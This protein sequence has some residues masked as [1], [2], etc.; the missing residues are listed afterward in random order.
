VAKVLRQQLA[1]AM[2]FVRAVVLPALR[3]GFEALR[4]VLDAWGQFLIVLFRRIGETIQR[5]APIWQVMAGVVQAVMP[6]IINQVQAALRIIQGII[7]VFTAVISGN[8]SGAWN[9]IKNVFGGIWDGIKGIV[10][11]GVN[12]IRSA[13]SG[14]IGWV[15]GAF[16]GIGNMILAPFR[17]AIG[18]YKSLWNSTIGGRGFTIPDIP[19]LPGRGTRVQIPTL[20]TGG[21]VP[22]R[23]GSEVMANLQAGEMVLSLAQVDALRRAQTVQP[24]GTTGTVINVTVNAG[25]GDAAEIGRKTVEAIK[26][27]ESRNGATWRAA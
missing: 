25:V 19:G 26:A 3:Q 17:A 4:P 27:Y 12:A 9:G 2:E 24:A 8:W 20:H 21:I 15:G 13:L 22:G 16:S 5:L 10:M 7:Q 23:R 18:A 11:F 1:M 6:L 14:L